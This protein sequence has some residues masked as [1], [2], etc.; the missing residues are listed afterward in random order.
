MAKKGTCPQCGSSFTAEEDIGEVY[1]NSHGSEEIICGNCNTEFSY[2]HQGGCFLTTAAVEFQGKPDDCR[3]LS[4]MR[5]LRDNHLLGDHPEGEKMVENYYAV[6]PEIVTEINRSS[7]PDRELGYIW[8]EIQDIADEV[9]A[10]N[11][12]SAT[13]EYRS[14]VEKMESRH[15]A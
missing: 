9:E 15:L 13:R 7:D 4:L 10:N 14:L 3:E 5:D 6:A 11:L 12:E 8:S 1:D 2:D